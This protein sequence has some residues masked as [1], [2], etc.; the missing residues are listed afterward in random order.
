MVLFQRL[1][2]KFLQAPFLHMM[3]HFLPK[4][5]QMLQHTYL[6]HGLQQLLLLMQMQ[7]ILQLIHQQQR[8]IQ[9]NGLMAMVTHLKLTKSNMDKFQFILAKIQQR[10]QPLKKNIHGI[11]VGM[12]PQQKLLEMQLIPQLL[13]VLLV[14]IQSH[15][16]MAMAIHLKLNKSLM[17]LFQFIVVRLQ[18]K[19]PQWKIHMYL[20]IHGHLQFKL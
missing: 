18:K 13:I 12:L 20:M 19:T 11:V 4:Q 10:I 6:I 8:N 2:M 17:V 5:K 3:E 1:I 15:G 7:N 16:L 9:S 14:N